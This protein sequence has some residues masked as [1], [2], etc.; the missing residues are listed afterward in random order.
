MPP[1][2]REFGLINRTDSGELHSLFTQVAPAITQ[3]ANMKHEGHANGRS[4]VQL[5]AVLGCVVM[6]GAQ[7]LS[8]QTDARPDITGT[9]TLNRDLSGPSGR[10]GSHDG[11]SDD[12]GRHSP[13][14]GGMGRP[15][16]GAP[17]G[18]GGRGGGSGGRGGG[19]MPDHEAMER[20]RAAMEAVMRKSARLIIVRT[21]T[22]YLVTDDDGVSM[23]IPVQGKKDT[24]AVNGAPF[25]TT[26]KWEEE[27]L[28]VERKFKGGLKVTDYYSVAGEPRALT[29]TSTIEGGHMRGAP[30]PLNRVYKLEPQ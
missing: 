15:G 30:P 26:T 23:R 10:S 25:E 11:G 28:R 9:W 2:G 17:G 1:E 12:E 3:D 21:D 5:A 16:G 18:M 8:G 6:T 19:E 27:K 24:G 20:T 14:G 22:G 29:V 4:V 7:S 13:R